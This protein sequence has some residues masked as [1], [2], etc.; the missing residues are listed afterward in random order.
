[1]DLPEDEQ[2]SEL[3]ITRSRPHHHHRHRTL[4]PPQLIKLNVSGS[5][6]S[7]ISQGVQ[8]LTDLLDANFKVRGSN[9]TPVGFPPNFTSG[10]PS[11]EPPM[12]PTLPIRDGF[13]RDTPSTEERIVVCHAYVD[14][15]V[16]DPTGA[17]RLPSATSVTSR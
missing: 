7:D 5:S 1:M 12:E 10:E 17:A 3:R 13:A 9:V 15:P 4:A 6:Y 14:E 11:S 8:R 16:Y 2:A